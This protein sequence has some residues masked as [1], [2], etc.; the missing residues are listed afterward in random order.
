[1]KSADQRSNKQLYK[2]N[3]KRPRRQGFQTP[4]LFRILGYNLGSSPNSKTRENQQYNIQQKTK[5][6]EERL[7]DDKR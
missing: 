1:M 7:Y 2:T 4:F 5:T 6:L 3:E